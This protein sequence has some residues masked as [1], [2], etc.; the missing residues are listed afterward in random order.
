MRFRDSYRERVNRKLDAMEDGTLPV[1]TSL[2][3]N[4]HILHLL[5]TICTGGLWLPVWVIRGI[6]GN[7]VYA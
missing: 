5:L 2:T 6:Q 3:A 1:R 7:K 4:Q